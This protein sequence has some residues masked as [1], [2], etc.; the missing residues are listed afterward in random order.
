MLFYREKRQGY[1][2]S[3]SPIYL[4][5][6]VGIPRAFWGIGKIAR[7]AWQNHQTSFEWRGQTYL[8]AS[9]SQRLL[10]SHADGTKIAQ[11]WMKP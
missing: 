11:I 3:G 5:Q 2:V 8:L 7:Q 10:I 4:I 9:T 1:Q 6:G